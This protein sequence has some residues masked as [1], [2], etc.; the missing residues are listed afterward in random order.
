MKINDEIVRKIA[1]QYTD[2]TL[3]I[4][5]ELKDGYFNTAFALTFGDGEKVVLKIAPPKDA[6]LLRQEKDIMFVETETMLLAAART[7]MPIPRILYRSSGDRV[8]DTGYF[9]MEYIGGSPLEKQMQSLPGEKIGEI[10]FTLGK[11]AKELHQITGPKFGNI[12]GSNQYDTWT[13]AFCGMID[14]VL[15][16]A[17]DIGAALPMP[18]DEIRTLVRS[19]AD[20]LD[21]VKVPVLLH[22]DLWMGNIFYDAEAGRITGI[23]DWERS[24]Y[25]DILFEFVCGFM[26]GIMELPMRPAFYAGYAKNPDLSDHEKIR[27]YLYTLYLFLLLIIEP[28]FRKY[29]DEGM[30]DER[31]IA[32]FKAAANL[33][34]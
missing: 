30:V 10:Y 7:S 17:A 29:E 16:D 33:L 13:Q 34:K 14:D 20:A 23:I 15:A 32:A 9:I 1:C 28:H 3:A 31:V 19:H 25:G 4:I 27:V 8:L 22:R 18:A 2:K 5:E 6:V 24:V 11:Y 26:D 21:E 12:Y